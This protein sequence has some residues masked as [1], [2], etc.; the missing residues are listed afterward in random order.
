MLSIIAGSTSDKLH[1]GLDFSFPKNTANYIL[2]RIEATVHPQ[3]GGLFSNNGIRTIRFS[4]GDAS[5]AF[6]CGETV[7]LA[8][9]LRNDGTNALAPISAT[10]GSLSTRSQTALP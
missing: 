8:F 1:E 5:S 4:L 6:L 9:Y 2:N 10:P 3:S 7:R